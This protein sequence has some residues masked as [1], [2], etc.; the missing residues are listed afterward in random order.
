M[1]LFDLLYKHELSN[2]IMLSGDIHYGQ[3]SV[4]PCGL[5][6]PEFTS[7]GLTHAVGY[8]P[9]GHELMNMVQTALYHSTSDIISSLNYG[10]IKI[11][12]KNLK[13]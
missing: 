7:S 3:I 9:F 12:G 6:T 5:F 11:Q 2:V 10:E 8:L 1:R 13:V 4:P